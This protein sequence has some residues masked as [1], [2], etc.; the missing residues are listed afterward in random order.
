MPKLATKVVQWLDV[1][2]DDRIWDVGCGGEFLFSF[3][4]TVVKQE[5]GD[6]YTVS[7]TMK[8]TF[9]RMRCYTIKSEASVIPRTRPAYTSF[10]IKG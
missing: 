8:R 10:P 4:F 6:V 2:P 5:A 9:L 3:S 7:Y 1:Q